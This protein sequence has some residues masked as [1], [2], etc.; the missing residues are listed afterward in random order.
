M[1]M[2][3]DDIR[4]RVTVI[5]AWAID[6]EEYE[7]AHLAEAELW[8]DVLTAIAEG[9]QDAATLA[10]TALTSRLVSYPRGFS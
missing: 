3:T 1:E 9:A 6:H 4:A 2:T 5:R 10:R 7:K 8:Q